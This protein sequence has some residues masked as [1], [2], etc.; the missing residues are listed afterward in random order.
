MHQA[1][2]WLMRDRLHISVVAQRLDYEL[3]AAFS[4]ACKRIIGV[5]PSEVRASHLAK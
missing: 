1:R 3:K 4:R 2:L 5:A